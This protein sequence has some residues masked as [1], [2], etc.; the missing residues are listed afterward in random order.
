MLGFHLGSPRCLR[1]TSGDIIWQKDKN[2]SQPAKIDREVSLCLMVALWWKEG[3]KEGRRE[4]K[5]TRFL[6]SVSHCHTVC[7]L[8]KASRSEIETR[9]I[10]RIQLHV[11]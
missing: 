3:R 10:A 2:R 5:N 4:G 7:R 6:D 11:L 8:V 9:P 1:L